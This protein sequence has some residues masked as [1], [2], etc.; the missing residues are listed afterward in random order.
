M[1]LGLN[2]IEVR[3]RHM[4]STVFINIDIVHALVPSRRQLV[5]C[6]NAGLSVQEVETTTI[7]FFFQHQ[8]GV[9]TKKKWP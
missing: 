2:A 4:V 7:T 5:S 1:L 6:A 3:C 9:R 8:H